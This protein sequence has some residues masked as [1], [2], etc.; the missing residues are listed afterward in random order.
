MKPLLRALVVINLILLLVGVAWSVR[1]K[2]ILLSEGELLLFELAPVDPRSLIQ[3]DYV[4]LS[5]AVAQEWSHDSLPKNGFIVVTKDENGVARRERLQANTEPL[6]PDEY[7]VNYSA[8]GWQLHIGAESYFFQE[9]QGNRFEAAKYGG[10]RV[11]G[12]GNSLLVGL[13][14]A[15]RQAIID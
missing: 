4:S 5:Y 1:E 13:F 9:G 11:D 12:R 8:S 15:N 2:E 10:L 6:A 14:D 7:L 3:G